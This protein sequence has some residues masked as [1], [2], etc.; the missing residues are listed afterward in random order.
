MAFI[1]NGKKT[2]YDYSTAQLIILLE[3]YYKNLGRKVEICF[4]YSENNNLGNT[5]F[6]CTAK[7]KVIDP[8][9]GEEVEVFFTLSLD[10]IK[11]IIINELKKD[12]AS[13]SDLVS[14]ALIED[15]YSKNTNK[16][17]RRIVNRTFTVT[18]IGKGK[19]YKRVLK[20]ENRR[21]KREKKNSEN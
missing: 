6:S 17:T 21:N 15:K 12:S 7:E 8:D 19:T 14:N 5:L 16:H 3:Y 10:N 2:T 20:L 1:R 9:T 11:H 13:L 4:D 18:E